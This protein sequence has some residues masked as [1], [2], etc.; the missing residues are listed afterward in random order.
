MHE[1]WMAKG[2]IQGC[3]K[4]CVA[5]HCP[6]TGRNAPVRTGSDISGSQP[7]R[8]ANAPLPSRHVSDGL[9]ESL[10]TLQ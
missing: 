5:L 8:H 10:P 9:F 7:V 4:V 1:K 6:Q 3:P 2:S